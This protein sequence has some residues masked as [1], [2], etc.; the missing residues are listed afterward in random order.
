MKHLYILFISALFTLTTHAKGYEAE[1][2]QVS[3]SWTLNT[4]GS[5]EFRHSKELTIYTHTAMNSTYGESFIVYNPTHQKVVIHSAYT[6]QKDG[7]IVKTP[8]NAFVEVLPRQ[9]A[10]APDFNHLKELVVVHTGLELGATI[11]LD[12]SIITQ[13]GYL[14][15]LDICQSLNELSPIRNY[16]LT[17]TTPENISLQSGFINHKNT[18]A[19]VKVANGMRTTD[20]QIKNISP[21]SFDPGTSVQSGGVIQFAASTHNTVQDALASLNMLIGRTRD[22]RMSILAKELT[23]NS[24]SNKEKAAILLN[25]VVNQVDLIPLSL[26]ESG[27]NIRPEATLIDRAYGTTA[28]KAALLHGLLKA[29]G[30][31]SEMIAYYFKPVQPYLGLSAIDQLGVFTTIDGQSYILSPTTQTPVQY[32][33]SAYAVRLKDGSPLELQPAS[34]DIQFSAEIEITVNQAKSKFNATFGNYH[35][36]FTT[37]YL[38]A[39][40]RGSKDA[41]LKEGKGEANVSYS[42]TQELTSTDGYIV[43]R[44]PQAAKGFAY[45]GYERYNSTRQGSLL[46][47][48]PVNE[49]Y[50]YSIRWDDKLE[51]RTPNLNKEIKNKAGT[52]R[53]EYTVDG[54]QVTIRKHLNINNPI[55]TPTTYT[56]F[57]QLVTAWGTGQNTSLLFKEQ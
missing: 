55:I 30:I 26:E 18:Q 57:K 7:N 21:R 35:I 40:T 34:A 28:E 33:S 4:D 43:Y 52:L 53:I 56:D 31:E 42:S 12:Y 38:S 29:S 2:K 20:Y 6:K 13:A 45:Q 27:F 47:F 24:Q 15:Q 39:L 36:P 32:A 49:V 48:A 41:T 10:N 5:Q 46:L 37:N 54:N 9:A 3:K 8:E 19:K 44:L 1:F 17:I 14:K 23:A 25:Y 22:M 11:Y 51:L 50:E 16:Q